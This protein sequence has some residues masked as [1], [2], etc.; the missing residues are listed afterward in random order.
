MRALDDILFGFL[1]FF[2]IERGIRLFSNAVI[3]PWA[4]KKTANKNVI[5]NWKLTAE[6]SALIIATFMVYRYKDFIGRFNTR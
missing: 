3:E 2:A 5:E 1:I 6:F 4:E